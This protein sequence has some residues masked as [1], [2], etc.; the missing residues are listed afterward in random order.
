MIAGMWVFVSINRPI[1]HRNP[2]AIRSATQTVPSARWSEAAERARRS[3]RASLAEEN[4]PGLSVAVGA[5]GDLVWS[6]GFGWANVETR[7]PV[8][9]D[10][11]FRIGTASTLLT[12][13]AAGV[14]LERGRLRPDEEIQTY[15]P[16][17][18]KKQWP[19]TLRQ[20]MADVAGTG[21]D[22]G[23]DGPV[24]SQRCEHPVEAVPQFAGDTLL[25]EPGTQYRRSKY[26]WILV[27]AAV[28]AAGAQP[29]L[30][31]MREQIFQPL[32]MDHTGAESATEENP[33]RL[34]EEAEDAPFITGIRDVILQPL[35]GGRTAASMGKSTETAPF[36]SPGFGRDPIFRYGVRVMRPRNLSCYAGSMAFLSTPSDLVRFGLAING[37]TL[38]KP[39]T[40]RLLQTS[41]R[42]RTGQE[43]DHGLGWD[44]KT[45]TLSGE[46]AQAIGRDGELLGKKIGSLMIFRE[47]GIVVVVMSNLSSA[48]TSGLT[49]KVAEA[50]AQGARR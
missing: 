41:Q 48:D 4:L 9:P 38:L 46:P 6:E 2:Q 50:F 14:L 23:D 1:L 18:P 44:L 5:G 47:A 37:G 24:S 40:V 17:F 3:I 16:Q 10:T 29:F 13:A 25:F 26:G 21:T 15:V 12:S 45:V 42:L 20:L 34:G 33:D 30:G 35:I 7:A 39:D 28:E 49:L 32:H 8:T 43:T 31:F 11:R 36:Y 22:G 19:V 27:S